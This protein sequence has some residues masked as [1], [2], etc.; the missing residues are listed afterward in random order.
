MAS[1]LRSIETVDVEPVLML[2][3]SGFSEMTGLAAETPDNTSH[4]RA[5]RSFFI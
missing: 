3:F 5:Q 1:H 4:T 2:L